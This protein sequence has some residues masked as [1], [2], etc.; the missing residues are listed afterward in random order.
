MD[1]KKSLEEAVH[2]ARAGDLDAFSDLVRAFETPLRSWVAAHCPPGGDAD[3]VAQR[4]FVQAFKNIREYRPGTDFQAWLFTIARYQLL[5]EST[6]LRRQADY[7]RRYA[8]LALAAELERR[9]GTSSAGEPP[10]LAHLR[11]CLGEFAD[12]SRRMLAQRY[13]EGLPLDEIARQAGRSVGAVKQHLFLLRTKL[14]DCIARR[15][16]EEASA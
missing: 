2:R 9:T 15:A 3:D 6:R 10:R 4:T 11:R 7:H 16:A 13:A 8:P 12:P 5:A 14:H 1:A